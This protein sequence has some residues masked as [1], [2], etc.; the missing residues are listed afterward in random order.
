[1][2][3]IANFEH[4]LLVFCSTKQAHSYFSKSNCYNSNMMGKMLRFKFTIS[5][6]NNCDSSYFKL[7]RDSS[8]KIG[9]LKTKLVK[10]FFYDLTENI[11]LSHHLSLQIKK[12]RGFMCKT[13]Y[14]FLNTTRIFFAGKQLENKGMLFYYNIGINAL[15]SIVIRVSRKDDSNEN[16]KVWKSK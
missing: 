8:F 9:G 11:L 13:W 16:K 2:T 10:H 15:I 3:Q 6:K 14:R 7:L 12:N 4:F 1:M 5:Q